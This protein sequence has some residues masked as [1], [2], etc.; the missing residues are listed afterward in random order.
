MT[1]GRPLVIVAD[2]ADGLRRWLRGELER[3][4]FDVQVTASGKQAL[5]WIDERPPRVFFVSPFLDDVLGFEV[6]DRMRASEPTRY[7]KIVLVGALFRAY[8]YHAP[9][10]SLYGADAYIEEGITDEEFDKVLASV[11]K[12]PAAGPET[13]PPRAPLAAPGDPLEEART[14]ARIIISDIFIYRPTRARRSIMRGCF[15]E[16][17][18]EDLEFGS[19][20]FNKRIP[21]SIRGNRDIFR[22]ALQEFLA[23][24]KKEYLA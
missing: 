4:R 24:K 10:K 13:A 12:A 6:I 2:S 21:E 8:R 3:R 16:V 17:F 20:Y 11:L 9:P 7:T 15:E 5:A 18:A 19:E 22:E 23:I 14:L 1:H